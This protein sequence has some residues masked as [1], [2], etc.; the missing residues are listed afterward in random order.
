[1][2]I[3]LHKKPKRYWRALLNGEQTPKS[4]Y[5]LGQS[6]SRYM[7]HEEN[8]KLYDDKAKFFKEG[9]LGSINNINFIN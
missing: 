9:E 4:A 5:I 3:R 7:K 2:F 1:M 6:F 8:R